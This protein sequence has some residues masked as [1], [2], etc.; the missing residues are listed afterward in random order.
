MVWQDQSLFV[1]AKFPSIPDTF[2]PLCSY[3][4]R[5]LA[6]GKGQIGLKMN[7][8]PDDLS[9]RQLIAG[10]LLLQSSALLAPKTTSAAESS[11][12]NVRLGRGSSSLVVPPL[13]IGAWSWGDEDVW[14]YGGYDKNFTDDS[15]EAAFLA[16][17]KAGVTFFD[18][19]EVTSHRALLLPGLSAPQFGAVRQHRL[20]T[21]RTGSPHARPASHLFDRARA[22]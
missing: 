13:G 6:E 4:R 3:G 21:L 17:V 7:T 8:Q 22:R 15:I 2:I 12:E 9:R 1:C 19:A 14:G 5:R 20:F 16:A 11:F 18:T 10:L